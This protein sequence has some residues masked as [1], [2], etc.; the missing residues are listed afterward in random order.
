MEMRLS[1]FP[2]T[3]Y[4]V[5]NSIFENSIPGDE[6]HRF[7]QYFTRSDVV[8]IIIGFCVKTGDEMVLDPACGAG[9]FLTRA[10]MRKKMKKSRKSHDEILSELEGVDIAESMCCLSRRNLTI[11]DIFSGFCPNVEN[12]DFFNLI[13][14]EKFDVVA[15]NPPYMRQEELGLAYSKDYKSKLK[16]IAK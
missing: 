8:D 16:K 14:N 15:T 11:K 3:S 2:E 5:R 6:R 4:E 12:I 13:P 9:I 1:D 10:Y 7:G